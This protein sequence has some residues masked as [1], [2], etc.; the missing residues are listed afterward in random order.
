MW[1][2]RQLRR[3]SGASRVLKKQVISQRGRA[4]R[5]LEVGER[6][7]GRGLR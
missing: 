7:D 3:R 4:V 2:L 1:P 6:G 5:A